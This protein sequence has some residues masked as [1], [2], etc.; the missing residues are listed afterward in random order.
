MMALSISVLGFWVHSLV[1]GTLSIYQYLKLWQFFT[2][3]FRDFVMN[4]G[5]K[6]FTD[7]QRNLD[8]AHIGSAFTIPYVQLTWI[9]FVI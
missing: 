8:M 4:I 2:F 9:T 5:F 6:T 1:L 7:T 3:L